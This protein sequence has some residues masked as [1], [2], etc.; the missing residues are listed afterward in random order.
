[1][2]LLINMRHYLPICILLLFSFLTAEAQVTPTTEST[3]TETVVRNGVGQ[4]GLAQPESI[5]QKYI[6]NPTLDRYVYTEK[7]GKYDLTTPLFLTVEEFE[8]LVLRER[9]S[10]YY[11]DKLNALGDTQS[12]TS[13]KKKAQRDLLPDLYINS[14]FFES[15]FGGR[16]IEFT[17]TGS[18]G[19]DFGLR[20][21]RNDNPAVSPR[22][23]SSLGLDFEQRIS[24][25][26]TGKIGTRVNLNAQYD[27]QASFDFQ[28]VFKLEYA[29]DED[30][31]VQK[32]ELGNISMLTKSFWGKNRTEIR[33]YHYYRSF[34]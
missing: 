14:D 33:S 19:V 30:D 13:E 6:Y 16:N 34:L 28:N 4:I 17:P 15:I 2:Y 25:G 21:S 1:M 24:L 10:S 18:V 5:V 27:T 11:K 8:K 20:Y 29:P 7:L 22:Y 23:R 12:N 9:M 26:L 3:Q 31:I 32:I